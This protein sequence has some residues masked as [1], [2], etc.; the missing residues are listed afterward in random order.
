MVS[1]RKKKENVFLNNFEIILFVAEIF[2]NLRASAWHGF[3]DQLRGG[4]LACYFRI[5][6][7]KLFLS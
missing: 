5:S 7:S 1:V 3:R 2:M 6:V 4:F